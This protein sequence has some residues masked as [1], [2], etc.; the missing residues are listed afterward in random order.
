[1]PDADRAQP[2]TPPASARRRSSPP[3]TREGRPVLE[4]DPGQHPE[5]AQ[6]HQE[7]PRPCNPA[8]SPRAELDSR[9]PPLMAWSASAPSAAMI[10]TMPTTWR[11]L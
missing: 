10:R 11:M 4:P 1:V 7:A 5:P 6:Q 9:V 2:R 8:I 3:A